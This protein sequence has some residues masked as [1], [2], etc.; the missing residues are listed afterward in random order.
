MKGNRFALAVVLGLA[1]VVT[2][3]VASVLRVR[4]VPVGSGI[5]VLDAW[6]GKFYSIRDV[7]PM[8]GSTL[9][10]IGGAV[11]ATSLGLW[12]VTTWRSKRTHSDPD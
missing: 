8:M 5:L 2:F 10:V 1:F 4:S 12:A 11:V 3:A 9:T 7:P 6:T